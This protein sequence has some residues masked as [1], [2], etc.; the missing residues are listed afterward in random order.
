LNTGCAL[1][2]REEVRREKKM[3]T[4]RIPTPLRPYVANQSSV[5]VTGNTAG[6]ALDE[7]TH[8]YPELR[9]HLFD[10][11]KLRNFVNVYLNEE[12]I[13]YLQGADTTVKEEDTL[14]IIPSIAGG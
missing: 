1:A 10:G 12:D 2:E 11:D 9:Q 6:A 3:P 14:M 4:V 7:L 13:R 5:T 8:A